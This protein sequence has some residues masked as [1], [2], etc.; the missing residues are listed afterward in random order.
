[1]TQCILKIRLAGQSI[2]PLPADGARVL[3]PAKVFV[4]GSKH[5]ATLAIP[6]SVTGIDPMWPRHECSYID[7]TG[8]QYV[9]LDVTGYAIGTEPGAGAT[10][11]NVV[12]VID[13]NDFQTINDAEWKAAIADPNG[14]ASIVTLS[15]GEIAQAYLSAEVAKG[16]KKDGSA[17]S[18]NVATELEWTSSPADVQVLTLTNGFGQQH[19]LTFAPPFT[20]D[21]LKEISGVATAYDFV[22]QHGH[23]AYIE[24]RKKE[25]AEASKAGGD[26]IAPMIITCF[27][28]AL[29]GWD[30]T[31]NAN[32]VDFDAIATM[33]PGKT[34]NVD[35]TLVKA[36]VHPN[37]PQCDPM[38]GTS[39]G[40]K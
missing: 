23:A 18:Q 21:R 8:E 32:K 19:R 28:T 5:R 2:L 14:V 36:R 26:G 30:G 6:A 27:L 15:S 3:N 24:L 7:S 38:L 9:T 34:F 1:M 35:L 31:S 10:V 11:G 22:S 16:T 12:N 33:F 40:P 39:S 4:V 25:A 13:V 29:C 37:K 17:Y 20:T